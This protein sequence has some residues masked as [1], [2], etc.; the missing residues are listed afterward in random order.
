VRATRAVIL[1]VAIVVVAWLSLAR[2]AG[3]AGPP[4]PPPVENQAVYDTAGVLSE[5]TIAFAEARIDA[6]EERT[7]AEVV[8]YTQLVEPSVTLDEARQHAAALVGQWGVG[9]R[10]F[11]DGLV[12]LLDLYRTDP[13]HGHVDLFAG[14]GYE[15]AFLSSSERQ[16][17]FERDMLPR[18]QAGDID[19]AVRIAI[20]RIDAA[21][22][23]EHAA[24]L[25]LAR[26]L[27]AAIGLVLAP[28]ALIGLVVW[29][30]W[31][32]RRYGRD[33]VY[34]DDPS[35]HL[36]APPPDLTAASAALVVDGRTSRR[37]LTAAL[38]DLASRGRLSFREEKH[39][40]GLQRKVGIELD[41]KTADPV[42]EAQ[43]ARNARRPIAEPEE[44]VLARIRGL[45]NDDD[46][47]APDELLGFGQHVASFNE[48]LEQH[49]VDKGWFRE[50]PSKAVGRWVL[51]GILAVV[52]G[53]IA[54]GVGFK[55]IS[56]G[57][58]LIGGAALV[59]G[60]VLLVISRSMPAVTI[61]GAMIRAMLAA[62]RRTLQKTMAEARSMQQVV[63]EARL[64]WLETPDQAVVWGLA[65]GLQDEIE[66]VMERTFNDI[67]AG[68]AP[69]STYV[70]SWYAAGSSGGSGGSGGAPATGSLMSSSAIPNLGGMMAALGTIGNS[71]SS[72]GSGGGF[73][74]GSSGGGSSAG[75]S[76]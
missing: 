26:Q 64:G 36:P 71:P 75:G 59:G 35:I 72:S 5:E 46:Y 22:T 33:P 24:A 44:Y 10:G 21:A 60:L 50:R 49:V 45:G 40:L 17:V 20:E 76:F 58:V 66:E 25:Q 73:G 27:D 4:F 1:R 19:G 7:G 3:A 6:I 18:L 37:A 47:V 67:R 31:N 69:E 54:L 61:P 32:W 63:F 51:R 9:R 29:G 13:R 68:L 14:A 56:A 16:Q 39:M 43:R 15:A 70:P 41:P 8:V 2:V 30:F 65:L 62:Y 12:I 28:V 38:L 57:L 48:K 74:G 52:A 11:D 23:P 55:F 53:G 42:T 34:L